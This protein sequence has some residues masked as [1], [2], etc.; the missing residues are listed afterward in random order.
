MKHILRCSKC[1]EYTMQENCPKCGT[2]TD[3]SKPAKYSPEDLYGDYR[4]KA[5]ED[6]LKEK[7][8]I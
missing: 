1:E 5:K 4:R 6:I 3:N 2:K 7:G 8:L